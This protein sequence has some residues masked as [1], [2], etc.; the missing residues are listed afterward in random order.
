M[1]TTEVKY[2]TVR[3]LF[4]G[5]FLAST[6]H[7]IATQKQTTG[8]PDF[9]GHHGK[10]AFKKKDFNKNREVVLYLQRALCKSKG[11]NEIKHTEIY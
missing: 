4:G 11:K 2:K 7:R 10:I 1:A 6:L 9:C 3:K 8:T 5:S